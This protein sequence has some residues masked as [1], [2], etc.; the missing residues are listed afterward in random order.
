MQLQ[1]EFGPRGPYVSPV[2]RT[3]SM[4][5]V[6]N[7]LPDRGTLSNYLTKASTSARREAKVIAKQMVY[8]PEQGLLVEMRII[9]VAVTVFKWKERASE[10]SSP[11]WTR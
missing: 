6:R 5:Q 3:V 9:C 4:L 10:A 8:I 11:P 7:Y 2:S 1:K